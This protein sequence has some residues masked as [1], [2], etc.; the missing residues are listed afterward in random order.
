M[1][2]PPN[3]LTG[4]RLNMSWLTEQLPYIPDDVDEVTILQHTRAYILCLLGGVIA[5][6]KSNS[7]V[8]LMYLPLLADFEAAG[9]FSWGSACLAVLYHE[10]CRAS[11]QD[12]S[13]IA[14]LILLLQL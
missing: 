1:T 13:E 10:M 4:S 7:L 9:R 5:P 6:D 2:P 8:H 14:G 3:K 12:A 11:N